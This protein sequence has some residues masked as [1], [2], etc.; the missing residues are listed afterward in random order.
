MK[1][2]IW[3]TAVILIIGLMALKLAIN[4]KE[5][6]KRKNP[7]TQNKELPVAV[8]IATAKIIPVNLS[9]VKTGT[10]LPYQEVD[11]TSSAQGKLENVQFELGSKVHK[12]Q[13]LAQVDYQLKQLA[14]EQMLIT[15]EKLEKD[16][17]RFQEL[18]AGNAATEMQVNEIKFNLQNAKNQARQIKKQIADATITAPISGVIVRKNFEAG[19]FVNPGFNLGLIVDVSRMKVQVQV[20]ETEVYRVKEGQEVKVTSEVLPGKSFSGKVTYV[21]PKGD[22]T[23]NYLV[24]ITLPNDPGNSLKA[25]TFVYVDFSSETEENVLQI[26]RNALVESI[27]NPYVYVVEDSV[28][29][30]RAITVGRELGEN[31]EVLHGL[32]ENETVVVSGQINLRDNALIK[33]VE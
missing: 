4:K 8:A 9:L 13:L 33:V 17:A 16:S 18:L 10:L 22:D 28:A 25:G 7:V 19:E 20:G 11:I 5:L 26:P 3:I 24:E 21:S 2:I 32:K 27:R 6:N 29:K 14:L 30:L 15:I 31:I 23:H 12:G 1:K